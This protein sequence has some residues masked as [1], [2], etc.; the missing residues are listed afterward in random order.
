MFGLAF[1]AVGLVFLSRD[2][3]EA[4]FQGGDFAEPLHL[5]GFFKPF[6]GVLLNLQQ[7]RDLGEVKSQHRAANTSVFVLAGGA[8]GPVAGAEGDLA[9]AEVVTELGP[10]GVARLAVF[11]AGTLTAPLVDELPVVTDYLG[12]VNGDISGASF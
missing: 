9:E 2:V 4:F 10:F 5:A 8:V 3:P 12:R 7:A 11:F 1:D 6:N